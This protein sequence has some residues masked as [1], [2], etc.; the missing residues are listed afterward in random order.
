[1]IPAHSSSQPL[2]GG[3][4]HTTIN[5]VVAKTH[6]VPLFWESFS[7]ALFMVSEGCPICLS[8]FQMRAR[9]HSKTGVVKREQKETF[10]EPGGHLQRLRIPKPKKKTPLCHE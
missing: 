2:D 4:F 6:A 10:P 1:V 8:T 5:E 9:R 7:N 3:V